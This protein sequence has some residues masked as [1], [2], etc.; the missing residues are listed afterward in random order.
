MISEATVT[1]IHPNKGELF[2]P[3]GFSPN[4]DGYNDVL[5]FEGLEIYPSYKLMVYNR[6]GLKVYEA[7]TPTNSWDG[8]ANVS[9]LVTIGEDLPDGT[10][11]YI[12]DIPGL[13]KLT[14]F[15]EMMR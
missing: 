5:V 15:V 9:S 4:G 1:V 7:N 10:Y 13:D 11:Y 3:I 14:G 8:K 2:V 6:W 12:I